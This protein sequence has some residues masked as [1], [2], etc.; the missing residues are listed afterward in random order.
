MATTEM[1]YIEGGGDTNSK[2]FYETS[3]QGTKTYNV[4][5]TPNEIY[6]SG[7]SGGT[8]F[9]T[10]YRA[11]LISGKLFQLWGLTT[12]SSGLFV[13][14][15]TTSEVGG[16]TISG[17]NVTVN[18]TVGTNTATNCTVVFVKSAS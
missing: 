15:E 14:N 10:C 11:D 5:F 3:L 8:K 4:G 16:A 2:V 17:T 12:S 6:V 1:N 9:F 18:F 13:V 7:A